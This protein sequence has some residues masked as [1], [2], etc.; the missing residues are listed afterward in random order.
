MAINLKL[1]SEDLKEFPEA[2]EAIFSQTRVR[3]WIV[4]QIRSSMNYV[5]K[6]DRRQL[7]F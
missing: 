7:Y 3:L 6:K 5:P 2:V 4:H 1:H